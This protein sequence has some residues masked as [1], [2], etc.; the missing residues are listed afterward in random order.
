MILSPDT[1]VIDAGNT[2]V[3]LA[4]FREGNLISLDRYTPEQ[5]L[6]F[7]SNQRFHS[8]TTVVSSVLSDSFLTSLKSIQS[9]VFEIHTR[10]KLPVKIA[11]ETPET[12]GM[13]RLCN[14]VYAA[15]FKKDVVVVID[16]G[17]CIKFDVVIQG[18]YQGGAISP[19]IDLRY[20]ALN[21]YTALLPLL[22]YKGE[23]QLIGSNT[24]TSIQSGVLNGV[25]NE[26]AG[27]IQTYQDIYSECVFYLTGGD[28]QYFDFGGKNN[29]FVDENLTL[30]GLYKIYE[31]NKMV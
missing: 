27:G 30:K 7:L 17:T 11:Y 16:I 18:V 14:A 2:S 8:T 19:G 31:Y 3:K 21:E 1:L 4:G 29:I 6:H 26:L 28:C 23:N 15:N 25:R 22:S 13:D 20:K 9:D 24:I 12:L 10:L 5:I